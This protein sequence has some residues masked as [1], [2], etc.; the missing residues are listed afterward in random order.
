MKPWTRVGD[1]LYHI[2]KQAIYPLSDVTQT[3]AEQCAELIVQRAREQSDNFTDALDWITDIWPGP[4][5]SEVTKW[6]THPSQP[7]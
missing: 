7:K 4:V 5:R 6:I 2:D 3:T 1:N